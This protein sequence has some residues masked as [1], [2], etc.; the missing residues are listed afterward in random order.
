MALQGSPV[1]LY[2][3]SEAASGTTPT[4]AVDIINGYNLALNYGSSTMAYSELAAGKRGLTSTSTTGTHR[5]VKA[6]NDTSDALRDALAGITAVTLEFRLNVGGGNVSGGRVFVIGDSSG[7]TGRLGLRHHGDADNWWVPFNDTNIQLPVVGTSGLTLGNVHTLHV[8]IDTN[9]ATQNDRV[10]ICVNG[11]GSFIQVTN[12]ITS[13]ATLSIPSGHS[14]YLLNR[15]DGS[16]WARSI[17]GTVYHA[18]IYPAALTLANC[19]N[20]HT[21][22]SASDD[23]AGGPAPAPDQLLTMQ[24]MRPPVGRMR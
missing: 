20:N 19:Q 15:L 2:P 24:T 22:L 13:G 6:I 4:E 18:A 12:S 17:D 23:T 11:G 7:S 16:S 3:L 10:R 14:L 21:E 9:Q 8:V 5:G 1:V